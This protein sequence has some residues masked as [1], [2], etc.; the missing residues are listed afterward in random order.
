MSLNQSKLITT[1]T[2]NS[3]VPDVYAAEAYSELP[4]L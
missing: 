1:G 4:A 2:E 3:N